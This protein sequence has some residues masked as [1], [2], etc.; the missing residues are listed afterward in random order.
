MSVNKLSLKNN[1]KC[2]CHKEWQGLYTKNITDLKAFY[3]DNH[4]HQVK[5]LEPYKHGNNTSKNAV[6]FKTTAKYMIC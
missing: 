5:L 2:Y 6:L 4:F 3:N 1:T